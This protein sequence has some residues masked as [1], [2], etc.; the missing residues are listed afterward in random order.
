VCARLSYCCCI[1]VCIGEGG[2]LN[3]R[4]RERKRKGKI[5]ESVCMYIGVCIRVKE[6]SNVILRCTRVIC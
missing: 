1:Q 3:N 6:V 4:E 2:N 5:R